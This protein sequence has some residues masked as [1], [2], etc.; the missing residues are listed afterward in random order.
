MPFLF[1]WMCKFILVAFRYIFAL[2]YV[3]LSLS[4]YQ[5]EVALLSQNPEGSLI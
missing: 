1:F 3:L 2:K 5:F 4:I